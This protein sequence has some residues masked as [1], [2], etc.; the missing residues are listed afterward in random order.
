MKS[1]VKKIK[2]QAP[3]LAVALL[4]TIWLPMPRVANAT[5]DPV[6]K[7]ENQAKAP[8]VQLLDVKPA[9]ASGNI[10]YLL[11]AARTSSAQPSAQL[12]AGFKIKNNEADPLTITSIVYSYVRNGQPVVKIM[13]LDIDD[14]AKKEIAIPAGATFSWQNSR[15]Y[16]QVDNALLVESPLP[17]SLTN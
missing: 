15:D 7:T 14:S 2:I 17:A 6:R 9:D 12:S 5:G 1:N 11:C 3:V 4:C 16:H 10:Y 8:S 13:T